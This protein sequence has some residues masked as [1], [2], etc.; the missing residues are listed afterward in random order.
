MNFLNAFEVDSGQVVT[1]VVA[2]NPSA[3]IGG[4]RYNPATGGLFIVLAGTAVSY[5]GGVGVD[6]NGAT[7][8]VDASAGLPAGTV[9]KGRFPVYLGQL[10]IDSVNT[11]TYYNQGLPYTTTGAVATTQG[12]VPS[13]ARV[14]SD[15]SVRVT[16]DGSIRITS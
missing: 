8:V 16:S 4:R 7:L 11:T 14:T 3:Y 12:S 2:P 6:A 15:G 1:E 10:C 9:Y 13:N 5:S